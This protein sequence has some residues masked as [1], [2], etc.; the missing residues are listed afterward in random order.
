M[1]LY[2]LVTVGNLPPDL[3][4]PHT[5]PIESI[6]VVMSAR[7]QINYLRPAHY[8]FCEGN[9][10]WHSFGPMPLFKAV[11]TAVGK[12][13]I[14]HEPVVY[15]DDV[16]LIGIDA[17]LAVRQRADFPIILEAAVAMSEGVDVVADTPKAEGTSNATR[18]EL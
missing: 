13:R 6:G 4:F 11:L 1:R 18:V 9:G 14:N 8:L 3:T 12:Y 5:L 15:S 17:I 2:N 7:N 16:S 10:A